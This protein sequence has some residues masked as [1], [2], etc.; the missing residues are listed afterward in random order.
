MRAFIKDES[1][2]VLA[3]WMFVTAF[4]VILGAVIFTP[5]GEILKGAG[6]AIGNAISDV[7]GL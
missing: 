6:T 5:L 1:G 3:P 2:V 7:S 4:V